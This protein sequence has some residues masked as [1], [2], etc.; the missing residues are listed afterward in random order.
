MKAKGIACLAVVMG[1]LPVSLS[2]SAD[3]ITFAFSGAVSHINDHGAPFLDESI[4]VHS[5]MTAT[6]TFDPAVPDSRPDLSHL[7]VYRQPLSAGASFTLQV[8]NYTLRLFDG[9]YVIQ[10]ENDGG[11]HGNNDKY[12]IGCSVASG[13]FS[14]GDDTYT[15]FGFV[16]NLRDFDTG[17]V[18][19]DTSLPT[20]LDLSNFDNGNIL[21]TVYEPGGSDT[22]IIANIHS[23]QAPI[24]EPD[25]LALL[26]LGGLALLGRRRR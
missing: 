11:S 21:I 14:N 17:A 13:A 9:Y 22:D 19:T 25:A 15:S 7:G 1:A 12:E 16:V 26:A 2:Y 5:P 18:F 23:L 3:A 8:G 6:Y 24:P 20:L 10:I 4:A